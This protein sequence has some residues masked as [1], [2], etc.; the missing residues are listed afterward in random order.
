[1]A[2]I[3]VDQ[4]WSTATP[5]GASVAAGYMTIENTGT[6]PDVLTGASTPVAGKVEVHQMTMDNGVSCGCV[7]YPRGSKSSRA[8]P[9]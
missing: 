4:P 3:E 1:V 8:R 2:S 7:R 6:E 9:F 5:P